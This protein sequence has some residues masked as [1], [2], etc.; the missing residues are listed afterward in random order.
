MRKT[1]VVEIE[2]RE[3][4]LSNLEKVMYPASGF[5][6]GQVIDYYIKVSKFILPHLEDRPLTLKRYPD[7]VTGQF[8]YEKN[9]SKHT[10]KWVETAAVKRKRE[11]GEIRYVLLN[12]LPTLVWAANL[13]S[14]ELHVL[15]AKAANVQRPT[16]IVFDLDPGPP[17]DFLTCAEVA[18]RLRDVLE[19][20]GLRSFVKSSGSKGLQ[21][22]VPLNT[23]VTYEQTGPLANALA[24]A[25]Q[26]AEP[27]LV[28]AK[29]AKELRGG[30]VF[31][32]WSQNT[33]HKTTV[34][35]Y[36]LRAKREAPFVSFPIDWNRLERAVKKGE[37]EAFLVTPDEA[38]KRLEKEGDLFAEVLTLKQKFPAQKKIKA[39]LEAVGKMKIAKS[40]GTRLKAGQY[41]GEGKA[42]AGDKLNAPKKAAARATK[43]ARLKGVGDRSIE[44]Y[45]AKRDFS[46][47]P[48]PAAKVERN[49]KQEIFVIQKHDASRL[50]YDFRLGMDGVLKS[51]AV[52]KGPPYVKA[53]RRLAMHV[54]DHPM[55]YKDFEGTIAPGNYGAGTVMVWDFGTYELMDGSMEQ[56]KLHFQLHGKKLEGEWILVKGRNMEGSGE[57][58]FLIKG[59]EPMKPLT[60]KEDDR[61]AVTGRT[62]EEIA[63]A[64]DRQ[65]KSNRSASSSS[66]STKRWVPRSKALAGK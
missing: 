7:G 2:G 12:N 66:R 63:R 26:R 45:Q 17:A 61:S 28:V 58:W 54:E 4:T 32:D 19:E 9:A 16:S 48:E 43:K 65:W 57:P 51:W 42:D 14:L 38:I 33:D 47:T 34:A 22:Y 37:R 59:G 62:L 40:K 30:K 18:I 11:A 21:M 64:N 36:S 5:T 20:M 35:V 41:A 39:A 10:P 25:L 60:A 29:M 44:A 46:R 6:K 13:A 24:E 27:D 15:L 3:V 31:I 49:G 55:S 1:E 53:E 52:P 23:A 50:H 56:G 8:F